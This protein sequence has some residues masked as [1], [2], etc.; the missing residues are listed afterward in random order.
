VLARGKVPNVT[1]VRVGK[2]KEDLNVLDVFGDLPGGDSIGFD[3]VHGYAIWRNNMSKEVDFGDVKGALLWVG[4][5]TVLAEASKHHFHMLVVLARVFGVYQEVV[6]VDNQK[7][8]MHIFEGIV[9]ERLESGRSVGQ[10]KGHN[11]VLK[12]AKLTAE[13]RLPLVALAH[14]HQMVCVREVEARVDAGFG[15]M[16]DEIGDEREQV[17]RSFW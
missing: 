10:A 13:G 14:P 6:E 4:D 12:A 8:V 11:V 3:G 7:F 2:A 15:D 1:L 16:V 17:K 9:H 5:K